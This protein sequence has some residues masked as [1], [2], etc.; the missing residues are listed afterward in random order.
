MI[1][2]R[3]LLGRP[4][5]CVLLRRRALQDAGGLKQVAN[6]IID[7]CALAKLIKRSSGRIW[8]GMTDDVNSIRPYESLA[9]IWKR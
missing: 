4:V 1:L 5:G 6:E 7:D 8:M 2:T 3:P 9:N